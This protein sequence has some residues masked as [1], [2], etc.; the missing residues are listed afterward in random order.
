MV[1]RSPYATHKHNQPSEL[2]IEILWKLFHCNSYIND[3]IRSQFCTCH[4]SLAVVLCAKLWPDWIIIFMQEEYM[5]LFSEN[6]D[7][8]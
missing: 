2:K 7:Q 6:L 1:T 4:S 8:V 5:Y 3:T